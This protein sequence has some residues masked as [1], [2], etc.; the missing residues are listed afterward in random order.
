MEHPT[1]NLDPRA[2][3]IMDDCVPDFIDLKW[4]K[5]PHF[6]FL[7]RSGRPAHLSTIFTSP[8]PLAIPAHFLPHIDYVFILKEGNM[9]NR[10]KLWEQFG[11]MF[12]D[13]KVFDQVMQTCT[14]NFTSLVID[15]TKNTERLDQRLFYYRA[16]ENIN[17]FH[18][19]CA[20]LWDMCYQSDIKFHDL[21]TKPFDMFKKR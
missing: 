15:R 2:I 13:F 16:P 3:L 17:S 4:A 19:G 20:N 7:F 10:R 11:G 8:Y 1:L 18:L 6:K 21:L 14:N 9:K 12:D 5:N